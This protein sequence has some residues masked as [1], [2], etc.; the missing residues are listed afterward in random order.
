MPQPVAAIL[1]LGCKLNLA[2]SE[3]IARGLRVAGY[4]VVDRMCEA[5][6]FVVNTCSVTHVADQKSRRLVRSVRRMSPGAAV[7]V[8][9]C[10]PQSAGFEAVEALG[11]DLVVGTRDDGKA[12]LVRFLAGK[13]DG[14]GSRRADVARGSA[15]HTRAFIKAQEGCNDVCAFCIVPR[16]RGREQSRPVAA[17]VAEVQAAVEAGAREVVITGTQ[18]GAWGRDFDLP[19]GPHDLIAGVLEG[20]DVARLRFSSLQPQD[21]TP[22]LLGLWSDPRLMPHFHLALQ[23]GSEGVLAAMRRRYTA[24]EYLRAVDRIRAAAPG[25]AITTD[26]IAGFPGET[27]EQFEETLVLCREAGFARL[28]CFPYSQ[29]S[30]TAAARMPGQVPPPVRQERM[31]RLL[32]LGD[33]LSTAFREA[34]LGESRAVLW[35]GERE[36]DGQPLAFGHTDNY[37]PVYGD[38]GE[39]LRNRIT[40]VRI[41]EVYHDGVR[42]ILEGGDAR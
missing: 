15:L 33:E 17:V 13:L 4:R 18:L 20:T 28:H 9:G 29:R 1:T 11:A 31:R 32:A 12:E 23:S 38:G 39:E 41:G 24:A 34:A 21:I 2:D 25:V 7:T 42:G 14:P 6:A 27:D 5:D 35:E 8:T 3:E 40:P 30:R 36:V 26:V 37:I 22:A 10:F 16:T 19:R